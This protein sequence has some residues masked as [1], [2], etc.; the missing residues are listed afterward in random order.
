[1][2]W[3]S[4]VVFEHLVWQTLGRRLQRGDFDLIH[5]VTPLSPTAVSPLA[6][7][8][9]VPMIAGPAQRRSPLA[10]GVPGTGAPRTRVA[11]P[12]AQPVQ[13]PAVS[14]L[15]LST[16]GGGHHGQSIDRGRDSRV[17]STASAFTCRRM[18][19][20]QLGFPSPIVGRNRPAAFASSPRAASCRTRGCL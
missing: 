18:V 19:S 13:A 3:P 6:A 11:R 9:D 16:P 10:E 20:I 1:M 4:Y 5:R 2:A 12:T 15:D 7:K 8:T 14:P 17:T